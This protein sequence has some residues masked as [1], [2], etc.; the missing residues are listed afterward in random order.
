[1]RISTSLMYQ[2]SADALN[3]KQSELAV[4][5]QRISSGQRLLS[6]ADDPAAAAQG[7]TV[8][9]AQA[10]VGQYAANNAVAQ[11][12]LATDEGVLSSVTDVLQQIRTLA[13][14]GGAASLNA[15]DRASIATDLDGLLAQL[16]GLANSK[17]GDESY[18]FSGYAL[19][20]QPFVA[21]T[22]G[23][24]Y[25]GDQGQRMLEVG[26]GRDMAINVNGQAVFELGKTGNGTFATSA[27]AG[28][29][30]TGVI[31]VGSV[32]NPAAVAGHQYQIQFTSSAKYDVFDVT[33]GGPAIATGQDYVAGTAI[34]L[35]GIQFALTGAPA[36]GDTFA[37][38]PSTR[39]SVFTT[40]QDLIAT[41]RAPSATPASRAQLNMGLGSALAGLDQGLSNVLDVR[42][43]LGARL[44]E[45][46]SLADGN[47]GRSIGYT[48]TLSR[49]LELDY[50]QALT[51]FAQQQ[52]AL[53][54]AQ[55]SFVDVSRLSLFAYL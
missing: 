16:V 28:N 14:N 22:T 51:D 32:T 6:P 42:A 13:V 15:S 21:T 34:T 50:N 52:V 36:G 2:Q 45:L 10:R 46:D 24:T 17:G 12:A 43:G 35:P 49:L 48:Q 5:Q 7:V 23:I 37:V 40:V 20:T 30:G 9:A 26:S 39:Q 3:R 1:M 47:A 33:A 18:L 31:D 44:R 19:S 38:A 8:A 53:Q 25:Q 4:T 11:D 41:L 55:K 54:A 27:A 29:T